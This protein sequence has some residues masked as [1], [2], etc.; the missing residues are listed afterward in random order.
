MVAWAHES[1]ATHCCCLLLLALKTLSDL[2]FSSPHMVLTLGCILEPLFTLTAAA[3]A[4][5]ALNGSLVDVVAECHS[6]R[7]N[8]G[9]THLT[10]HCG[11]PRGHRSQE[12]HSELLLPGGRHW[13][14]IL[15]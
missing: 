14:L 1:A 13:P 11:D 7:G 8:T 5:G 9:L 12:S 3:V 2:W 4:E 15:S 10:Y 6:A